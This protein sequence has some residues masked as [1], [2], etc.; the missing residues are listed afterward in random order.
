MS[1]ALGVCRSNT[2]LTYVLLFPPRRGVSLVAAMENALQ[3][4]THR[5]P[6]IPSMRRVVVRRGVNL[7]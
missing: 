1:C 3:A 7:S 5:P 4:M 6:L 2:L